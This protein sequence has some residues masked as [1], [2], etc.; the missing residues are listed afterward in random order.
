MQLQRLTAPDTDIDNMLATVVT[1][2]INVLLPA[3]RDT[4]NL[5]TGETNT[6]DAMLAFLYRRLRV[7]VSEEVQ[8]RAHCVA[9]IAESSC[10]RLKFK[11]AAVP[12]PGAQ[13]MRTLWGVA[14]PQPKSNTL[15][16]HLGPRAAAGNSTATP[17]SAPPKKP[18]SHFRQSFIAP[19][20]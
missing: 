1:Q 7:R 17:R 11:L 10:T 20:I 6:A 3:V 19:C 8:A 12:K 2:L 16:T 13:N 4:R 15:Y 9:M 14:E 5:P 18:N